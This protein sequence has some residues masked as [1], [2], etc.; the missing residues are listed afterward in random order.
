MLSD[1]NDAGSSCAP[2]EQVLGLLNFLA[3]GLETKQLSSKVDSARAAGSETVDTDLSG[4]VRGLLDIAA[5]PSSTYSAS[6]KAELAAATGYG[7]HAAVHLM[8]THSFSEAILWLLDL[9]D[10]AIQSRALGLLRTRLPNIKPSRRAEISPAVVAVVERIRALLVKSNTDSE[11]ALETLDVV[12]SSAFAE[13]D[14]ALAKAVPEL[15]A[16]ARAAENPKSTRAVAIGILT[17][18]TCVGC[19]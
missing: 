5:P 9:A 11:G 15:M 12:A 6:D 18:L 2:Q 4:L 13:E 19:S 1:S 17:K 16:V 7:V 14:A 3:V 8:S 10:P